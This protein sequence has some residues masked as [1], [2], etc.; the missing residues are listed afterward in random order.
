MDKDK[1]DKEGFERLYGVAAQVLDVLAKNKCSVV[2]IERVLNA[3]NSF[4]R[5]LYE[6]R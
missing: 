2:E 5:T 1:F 3:M 6:K 4:F